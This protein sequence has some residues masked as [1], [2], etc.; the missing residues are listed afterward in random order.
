MRAFKSNQDGSRILIGIP[1][2]IPLGLCILL[3]T[4]QSINLYSHCRRSRCRPTQAWQD[5]L[6]SL[7]CSTTPLALAVL[8]G[9]KTLPGPTAH[10]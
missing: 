6:A 7:P 10:K 9:R 3:A 8:P 1:T 5:R 4:L 2:A